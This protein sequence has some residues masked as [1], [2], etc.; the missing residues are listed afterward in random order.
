VISK[1]N[2]VRVF[3]IAKPFW[4]RLFGI[5]LLILVL[6]VSKNVFPLI[7]KSIF[8]I[9]SKQPTSFFLFKN[10]SLVNL[11]ALYI[12]LK[13]SL[14]ILNQ[15]SSYASSILKIKLGHHMRFLAFRHILTLSI[16][17]FNK[18]QSG[19][20]M[21]RVSRGV[22]G[23]RSIISN[24]GTQLIPSIVTSIVAVVIVMYFNFWIGFASIAMFLPYW[25]VKYWRFKI[26]SKIEKKQNR[27]WDRD[28]SHFWEVVSNIRIIKS[29]S[30]E[31]GELSKF[32]RVVAKLTV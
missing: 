5:S 14:T 22:D 26:L 29:F 15:A 12:I 23:V 19:K 4:G 13:L 11:L 27:V 28:Y 7:T 31:H 3:K 9:I 32:R 30:S 8:D 1:N 6:S 24:V 16:D 21:S 10:P 2:F 18:T 20:I 25:A 17:Y